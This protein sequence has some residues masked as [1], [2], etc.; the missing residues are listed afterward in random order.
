MV[1]HARK[2]FGLF[3]PEAQ[4]FNDAVRASGLSGLCMTEYTTISHGMQGAFMERWHR[5]TSSFHLPVGEMT[6]TLQDVE[7]LLPLPI[8]GALLHH[9]RIQR[10]KASKWMALCL[11]MEPEV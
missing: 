6:I 1:N 5:E 3:K 2:I 10:I 4:W 8:R 7:C 9:S 11:G